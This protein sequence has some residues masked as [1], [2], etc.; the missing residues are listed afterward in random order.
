MW[1]DIIIK[2]PSYKF[3]F[4]EGMKLITCNYKT[5]L[6][7]ITRHATWK[8]QNPM[9]GYTYANTNR[10]RHCSVVQ[11]STMAS[12]YWRTEVKKQI[13]TLMITMNVKIG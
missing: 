8:E 6:S 7:E 13:S 11:T 3:K 12:E 4:L 2:V 9:V 10:N 1:M 5:R